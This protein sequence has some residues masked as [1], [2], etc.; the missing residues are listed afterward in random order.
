M[1]KLKA[2]ADAKINVTQ[3]LKFVYGKIV[4]IVGKGEI[5][6][7]QYLLILPQCFRKFSF[8][9]LLSQNGVGKETEK[10]EFLSHFFQLNKHTQ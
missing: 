9:G 5:A 3:K 2:F 4:N 1:S 8:S 10:V 7:N 6:D